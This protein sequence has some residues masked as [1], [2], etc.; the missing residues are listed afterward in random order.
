MKH[1]YWIIAFFLT[2]ILPVKAQLVVN[3]TVNQLN[4]LKVNTA[5]NKIIFNGE[6]VQLLAEAT[7]GKLPYSFVWS[8][9]TGLNKA[10]IANPV[11]SPQATTIYSVTVK[12]A[13]GC[14]H[15]QQVKVTVNEYDPLK[16]TSKENLTIIK[17][18]SVQL[19]AEATGG[20]LPYTF[21]WSPADWLTNADIANP[22][23]SP[24]TTTTY[25]IT[26][27]DDRGITHSQAVK[28]TVNLPTGFEPSKNEQSV[29][30]YPN[31]NEGMFYMRLPLSN[32]GMIN[33]QVADSKGLLVLNKNFRKSD[34]QDHM[35]DLTQLSKGV[36]ILRLKY[37]N[38]IETHKL[39]T[40]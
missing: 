13:R 2:C 9:T 21:A 8:P 11:A 30:I 37:N 34:D 31:P 1:H 27:K 19:L 25:S 28:I 22:V 10:N 17:G 29:L 33:L 38:I 18:E 23:A 3:F 39:V 32:T 5:D 4:Q 40:Y 15:S 7:G 35:I 36:Y 16:V 26:V 12:D 6:S 14:T 20:K 24:L